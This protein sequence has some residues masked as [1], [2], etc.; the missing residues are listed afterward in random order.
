MKIIGINGS[1]RKEGNTSILINTIFEEL[2]NEGIETELIQIGGKKFQPCIACM[3]C[4]DKLDNKCHIKNDLFNECIE[5]INNADGVILG[6][7]VYFA[8]ITPEMK[9]FMD[10]AGYVARANKG[11]FKYK[12][13]AAV[14]AVRRAGAIHSIDSMNH[15]FQILDMIMPGSNY[16]NL[17]IGR[18]IGDVLQDTEGIET[19]RNLGKNIAW[20]LKKI[21][22]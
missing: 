15:F 4:F 3:K 19:M 18:N 14:A 21:K 7:P 8:D 12:I 2:H 20:L 22:Q 1:P 10:V 9:A 13:G 17:G 6:S 5:K 11:I 16:W